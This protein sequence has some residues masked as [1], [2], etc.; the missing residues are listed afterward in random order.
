LALLHERYLQGLD[1]DR[2]SG[3]TVADYEAQINTPLVTP[4]AAGG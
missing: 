4:S 2:P 3:R 1:A